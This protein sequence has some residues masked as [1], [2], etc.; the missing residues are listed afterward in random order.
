MAEND[1]GEWYRSIP[2]ITRW[3]FTLSV[4][5]PLLGRLGVLQFFYMVLDYHLVVH[6]FQVGPFC[7]VRRKLCITFGYVVINKI[8]TALDYFTTYTVLTN[9]KDKGIM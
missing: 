2:L 3:W 9:I 4:V 1:I 7:V 6:R 5:F 8:T